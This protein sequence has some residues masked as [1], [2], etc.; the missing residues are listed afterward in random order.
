MQLS[1]LQYVTNLLNIKMV[2]FFFYCN[3]YENSLVGF[4]SLS[5][6]YYSSMN[7]LD[8]TPNTNKDDKYQEQYLTGTVYLLKFGHTYPFITASWPSGERVRLST[9]RSKSYQRPS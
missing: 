2:G 7:R 4:F 5:H 8:K 9:R 3:M 1:K 6:F